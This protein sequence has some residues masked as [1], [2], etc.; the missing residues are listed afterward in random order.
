M[1]DVCG[2]KL[3][4]H[5]ATMGS[6]SDMVHKIP[7][8]EEVTSLCYSSA[9]RMVPGS[10]HGSGSSDDERKVEAIAN[11]APA[12]TLGPV[13]QLTV[14]VPPILQGGDPV[15]VT[16]DLPWESHIAHRSS[17]GVPLHNDVLV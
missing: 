1:G 3:W 2:W 14:P 17:G 4:N 6:Y 5:C 9:P 15:R 13:V 12:P 10:E 16:V 7:R 8:L 11:A